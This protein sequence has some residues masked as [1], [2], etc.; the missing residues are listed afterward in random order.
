VRTVFPKQVRRQWINLLLILFGS[1]VG[2]IAV[3]LFDN[4]AGWSP[5]LGFA[6]WSPLIALFNTPH[7]ALGLG[8]EALFFALVLRMS[9]KNDAHQLWWA[10][11][12]ALVGLL[13]SLVY[14]YHLAII[15]LVV[16]FLLLVQ[17]F[18]AR[19]IP[20]RQWA[21]GAVVLLPQLPLLYYYA[22][23][24]NNDPFWTQYITTTHVISPPTILGLL[25]GLGGL[26]VLALVGGRWWLRQGYSPLLPI[27]A[28]VNLAALYLPGIHF[29][30][31]FALGLMIPIATLATAGL[32]SVIVAN[33]NEA[34]AKQR[35]AKLT[36]TPIATLRRV[37]F[38][39]LLPST[40]MNILLF[41]QGPRQ[42]PD[43]PY[44]LPTS[45]VQAAK[46]LGEH[47]DETAVTL[48]YYPIG[49][50]LPRVYDGKVFMGQLDFT[51]N[52]DKKLALYEQF[53]QMNEQEQRR[54]LEAWGITH[55]FSGT[56]EAG[57]ETAV[58]AESAIVYEANGVKIFTVNLDK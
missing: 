54:F 55:I 31:R 57:Y 15:G 6:E 29:S 50:Y 47:A 27:W 20:W 1:G 23:Q 33:V 49:N 4:A 42:Q 34:K 25:V 18:Q 36:P 10:I 7:F 51:T 2:W 17:A 26:G 22:F 56:Y 14:V 16:G 13:D 48:S 53:W 9:R 21:Y 39:L 35:F 46:W 52:L 38:I 40:L 32:E 41:I 19:R 5:D 11:L 37:I 45:D 30:G 44:Y 8:L 58:S 24:T 43:F 12:A 28:T 3:Y